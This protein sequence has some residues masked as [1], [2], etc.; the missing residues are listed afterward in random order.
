[1]KILIKGAGDLASGIACRLHR[2][3]FLV[4]MTEKPVPTTV[5]RT[6]AFSRAVYE[7]KT[8]VEDITGVLCRSMKEV[9]EALS[10]DQVAVVVDEECCIREKWNPDAVVDAIIAKKNLGT[11]ITDADIVVAVGPGFTAGKDCHCVVETKRGHDLGR[12][13]WN[14]RAIPNTGVPGMIGGY[15]K[16]RIIRAVDNG[17]FHPAV[18]I[19]TVVQLN[20]VVGYVNDAPVL[21]QVG[22]VVR[23]LLQEGVTVFRGM[24]SGDI[25][26]RG[27]IEHCYTISDKAS[28]I[29]GGVLE[30]VLSFRKKHLAQKE[31]IST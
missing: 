14:G 13:I 24:K 2:C 17:I 29:G 1:M 22:G 4:V 20:D 28:A 15:D 16:E 26:P 7:N 11:R 3:G 23:G 27:V 30:A 5:R 12:C 8:K 31:G 9:E 6:V 25:D 10:R 21:A 19:G 18:T